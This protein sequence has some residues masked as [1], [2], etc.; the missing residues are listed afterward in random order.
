MIITAA[1]FVDVKAVRADPFLAGAYHPATFLHCTVLPWIILCAN[2]PGGM[3]PVDET[4]NKCPSVPPAQALPRQVSQCPAKR[5]NGRSPLDFAI[6]LQTGRCEMRPTW[7][8]TW[9]LFGGARS[10]SSPRPDGCRRPVRAPP[11][12][13]SPPLWMAAAYSCAVPK[14]KPAGAIGI[15]FVNTDEEVF[16]IGGVRRHSSYTL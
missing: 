16:T 5:F 2:P 9:R 13:S 15:I 1:K 12:P 4:P 6:V 11:P 8:A 7:P 3:C 10:A 14:T